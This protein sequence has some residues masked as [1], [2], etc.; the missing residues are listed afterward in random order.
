M[1]EGDNKVK[2]RRKKK[3][4]DEKKLEE[5]YEYYKV[6]PNEFLFEYYNLKKK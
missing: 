1:E 5:K 3:E 4:V 2:K 6:F